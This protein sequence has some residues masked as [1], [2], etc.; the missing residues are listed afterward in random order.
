MKIDGSKIL[1]IGGAGFIGSH[2]VDQ[3]IKEKSIDP[4][5]IVLVAAQTIADQGGFL[6]IIGVLLLAAAVAVVISTGMNYLLSPTTNIMRDVYQRFINPDATQRNMVVVQKV[7]IVI[8]GLIAFYFATN[9][10]SVL[11]MSFFAYTI[12]G[13]AI[14]P[15]LIAALAWKR[16]T[17]LGGLISIIG[18]ALATILLKL[19][20]YIWPSIMIPAGDP[21]GDPWGIPIIYPALAFSILSLVVFSYLS[22]APTADELKEMFP[23]K[24]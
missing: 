22:K 13:V 7:M 6:V 17:R 14:T 3:L 18:G 24:P 4:A 2:I 9:L 8:L 20:G 19:A 21:N 15:A 10:T 5:S 1:V 12:Y 23:E 11:E 16:A